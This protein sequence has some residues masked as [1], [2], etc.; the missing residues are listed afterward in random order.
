M[1]ASCEESHLIKKVMNIHQTLV[2]LPLITYSERFGRWCEWSLSTPAWRRLNKTVA[3]AARS[4]RGHQGLGRVVGF[5]ASLLV[6][7]ADVK[8]VRSEGS[9]HFSRK[10]K[11]VVNSWICRGKT[12]CCGGAV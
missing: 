6:S 12:P 9:S 11:S 4:K 2:P 10:D 8:S 3:R 5:S 1:A 7:A